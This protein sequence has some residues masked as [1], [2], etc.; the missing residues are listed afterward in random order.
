MFRA[1]NSFQFVTLFACL[2]YIIQWVSQQD[3]TGH[4]ALFYTLC[5]AY[6]FQFFVSVAALCVLS[7]KL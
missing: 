5:A 7:E 1:F 4:T 2:P 3:F 6:V